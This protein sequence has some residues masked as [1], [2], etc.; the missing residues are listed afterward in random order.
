MKDFSKIILGIL[1]CFPIL[2]GKS[3][4]ARKYSN[5]FLSIGINARALSMSNAQVATINNVS[6]GFWNPAGLVHFESSLQVAAMHSEY[7]AGIAKFDY[8]GIAIPLPQDKKIKRV[9]AFSLIRFGVD[10]IPYTLFLKEPDG[11]I[12]YDNVTSFSAAD[13]AFLF[14][15]AQGLPLKKFKDFKIGGTAKIIHRTAGEFAS[16]WGFGIDL[17]AQFSHE[18]WRFGIM[19]KDITTTFNAWSIRF[20]EEE[21]RV[22]ETEN[23]EVPES[24]LEITLPKL[25]LGGAYY[26]EFPS[27]I[28]ILPELNIDITTDGKRNVL[29]SANPFSIEPHLGVEFGYNNFVFVRGGIGNIQRALDN[30]DGTKKIITVQPN[31]GLGLKISDFTIDYALTDLGNV[32]QALY[33]HVFSLMLDFDKDKRKINRRK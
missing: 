3:Q 20:N 26:F 7:F 31:I 2:N 22:L 18:K 10:N 30:K 32:S 6:A 17:G 33:S 16:S 11:S 5:E 27:K 4:E 25:I 13:Y 29:I 9:I 24:S 23:N 14:S 21:K 1:L 19:A 8:G 28:S 15:Y 12:N